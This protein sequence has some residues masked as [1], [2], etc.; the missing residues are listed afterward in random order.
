MRF[1]CLLII[2]FLLTFGFCGCD[3]S[4]GEILWGDG[5]RQEE[6]TEEKKGTYYEGGFA[7][8]VNPLKEGEKVPSF[9]IHGVYT[10]RVTDTMLVLLRSEYFAHEVLMSMESPPPKELDGKINPVYKALI[11][12]IQQCTTY[13]NYGGANDSRPNN[14]FSIRVSV[15]NDQAFAKELFA[16]AQ[17]QSIAFIKENMPILKNYVGTSCEIIENKQ[18]SRFEY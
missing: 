15:E 10:K 3:G 9:R 2:S 13:E 1:L 5:S 7:L 6:T 18:I 4:F 8:Y 14:I 11:R 16:C 17:T 12:R